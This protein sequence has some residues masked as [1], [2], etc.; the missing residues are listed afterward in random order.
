MRHDLG[1][2]RFLEVPDRATYRAFEPIE[3]GVHA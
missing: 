2:F 3:R 1:V